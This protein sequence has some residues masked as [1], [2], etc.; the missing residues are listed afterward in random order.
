MGRPKLRTPGNTRTQLYNEGNASVQSLLAKIT[1]HL[2]VDIKV[3]CNIVPKYLTTSSS[4]QPQTLIIRCHTDVW[5][6]LPI[7]FP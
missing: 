2:Y 7:L 5:S 3:S 6:H 4:L 1:G